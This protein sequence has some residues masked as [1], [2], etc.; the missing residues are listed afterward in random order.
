[1]Q[2]AINKFEHA[3]TQQWWSGDC[4][5]S[6][7]KGTNSLQIFIVIDL[8]KHKGACNTRE[9]MKKNL[10]ILDVLATPHKAGGQHVYSEKESGKLIDTFLGL[11]LI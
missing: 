11:F 1:M 7:V 8:E 10:F 2:K 4:S 5:S 3:T 9:C 6:H